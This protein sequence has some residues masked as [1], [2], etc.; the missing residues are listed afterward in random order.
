[1]R[2]VQVMRVIAKHM[3]RHAE[4]LTYRRLIGLNQEL[5]RQGSESRGIGSIPDE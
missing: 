2:A 4:V 5:L 3:G 1:M